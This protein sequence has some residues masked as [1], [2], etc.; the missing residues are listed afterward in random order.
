MTIEDQI[1]ERLAA[2]GEPVRATDLLEHFPGEDILTIRRALLQLAKDSVTRRFGN[3]FHQLI[4]GFPRD[5]EGTAGTASHAAREES[6]RRKRIESRK[7]EWIGVPKKSQPMLD[8][9]AKAAVVRTPTQS[10]R[11]VVR[12]V[13]KPMSRAC[14]AF[15]QL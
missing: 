14:P 13:P 1:V 10:R 5:L 8:I 4:D 15:P 6:A 2:I 11:P 9:P 7:Y 12:Q 3:G